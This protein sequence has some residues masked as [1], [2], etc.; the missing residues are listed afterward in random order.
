MDEKKNHELKDDELEA[1]SGGVSEEIYLNEE[2][3]PA[4]WYVTCTKCR[5]GFQVSEGSCPSCGGY[6]VWPGTD[7]AI[8][9][10]ESRQK[11]P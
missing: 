5:F 2:R 11:R 7:R 3:M 1:V 4:G 8:A 10:Y 6:E 9:I